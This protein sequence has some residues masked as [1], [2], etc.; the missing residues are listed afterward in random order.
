MHTYAVIA[1]DLPRADCSPGARGGS[2]EG[3]QVHGQ[4]LHS[5]GISVSVST[6]DPG[7]SEERGSSVISLMLRTAV[8]SSEALSPCV[9]ASMLWTLSEIHTLQIV[10]IPGGCMSNEQ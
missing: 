7:R 1:V 5:T 4:E 6:R 3:S 10:I 2:F 9:A 8:G